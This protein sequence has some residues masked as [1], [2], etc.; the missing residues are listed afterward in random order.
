IDI[1]RSQGLLDLLKKTGGYQQVLGPLYDPYSG[2]YQYTPGQMGLLGGIGNLAQQPG[3]NFDQWHQGTIGALAP[4][5][6]GD[7][8]ANLSGANLGSLSSGTQNAIGQLSGMYGG[9]NPFSNAPLNQ[10]N[11]GTIAQF[12]P[13]GQPFDPRSSLTDPNVLLAQQLGAARDQFTQI[14]APQIQNQMA[15][16]GLGRSGAVQEALA[17][18]GTQLSLPITQQAAQQ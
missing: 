15:L 12:N 4:R 16:S 5:P 1:I 2:I 9:I 18:A 13:L 6:Y 8:L 3:M 7:A 10:L 14:V 17:R 11:M